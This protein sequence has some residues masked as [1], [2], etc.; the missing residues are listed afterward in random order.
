MP[1]GS[2]SDAVDW[3]GAVF[4]S[5]GAQLMDEDANITVKSDA[6]RQVL[7]WFQRSCRFC[8][9]LCSLGTTPAITNG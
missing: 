7:A 9:P 5:H 2:E 3:V 6:N 8:P 1:L 4:A